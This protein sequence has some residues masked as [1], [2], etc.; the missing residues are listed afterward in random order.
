MCITYWKERGESSSMRAQELCTFEVQSAQGT[1]V[2][3]GICSA[4]L[5]VV[6]SKE[7]SSGESRCEQLQVPPPA[8][9]GYIL[10]SKHLDLGKVLKRY[11][12]RKW[13]FHSV[14]WFCQITQERKECAEFAFP[15]WDLSDPPTQ[16][17][18]HKFLPLRS[19]QR[20]SSLCV[21]LTE[22]MP[23]LKFGFLRRNGMRW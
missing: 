14:I 17:Y 20:V 15:S 9:A 10:I 22:R 21:T 1:W 23:C 18:S 12:P 2:M 19:Y 7:R 8:F 5:S 4:S 3:A 11:S 13:L 16:S 6:C